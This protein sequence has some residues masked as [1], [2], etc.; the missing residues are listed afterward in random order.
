LSRQKVA[1]LKAENTKL[2]QIIK[3]NAELKTKNAELKRAV[4]KINLPTSEYLSFTIAYSF[5]IIEKEQVLYDD[6]FIKIR[7]FLDSGTIKN[8]H[9]RKKSRK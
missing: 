3:G 5:P 8:I 9:D 1:G 2:K 4:E 6:D 7:E